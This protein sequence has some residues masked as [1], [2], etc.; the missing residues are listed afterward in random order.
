MKDIIAVKSD[1]EES[2]EVGYNCKFLMDALKATDCEK[3]KVEIVGSVNPT[4]IK[5]SEDDEAFTFIVLPVRLK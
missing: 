4:V 3:I 1:S 2:F 5:P